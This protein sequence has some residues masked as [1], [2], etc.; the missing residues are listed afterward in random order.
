[1]DSQDALNDFVNKNSKYFVCEDKEK[2]VKYLGAEKIANKFDGGKTECIRYRFLYGGVEQ[3]WDR[4]SRR[5]AEYMKMFPE[6]C[7]LA[8]RKWGDGN[9]TKYFVREV[10]DENDTSS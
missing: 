10:K 1:M 6:G 4:G 9:Q 8:I 3:C 7:W 5:L 2:I